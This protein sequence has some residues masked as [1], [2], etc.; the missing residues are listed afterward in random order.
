MV[1]LGNIDAHKTGTMLPQ[2]AKTVI[3]SVFI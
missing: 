3:P 1:I 2:T